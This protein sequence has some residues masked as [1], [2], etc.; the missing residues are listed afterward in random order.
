[1][2]DV[3]PAEPR[4][5]LELLYGPGDGAASALARQI[6]AVDADGGLGRAVAHL[7]GAVGHAAAGEVAGQAAGLL[8]V[9]LADVL[10]AGWREHDDLRAAARRTLAVP[11]STELVKLVTHRITET[12]APYVGV[13]VDGHQVATVR[14]RLSL[15]LEVSALL[16]GVSAG[17]LVAV[18]AGRCDVTAA[19]AIQ[20]IDIVTRRARIE[21][22]GVIAL[23]RGIRLLETRE[24]LADS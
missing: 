7:P 5:A 8:D 9:N 15:G 17:K 14:F 6:L 4:S 12:Q 13:L 20:D 21:L 24:Y 10:V 22:S 3:L 19:L 18:H 1:M 23:G 2:T 11:G 16:A